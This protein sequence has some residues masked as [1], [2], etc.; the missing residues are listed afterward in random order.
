MSARK[1][2]VVAAVLLGYSS[3]AQ[4]DA[5]HSSSKK[6]GEVFYG[7]ASFYSNK[8]DGR[9]TANGDVFHQEGM[10]AACN[11]IA[12]N[13][14]VKVINE[15]NKRVVVVKVT[16]RMHPNN[17]RLIDLS[18]AAAKKLGYTGS[19]LTKVKVEVLGKEAPKGWQSF[20]ERASSQN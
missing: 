13:N 6:T 10:T 4:T 18:R 19:G 5:K 12:L 17:K 7:T 2:L 11:R 15:R 8:F 14:F 20:E 1:V 9:E 3:G 16:D